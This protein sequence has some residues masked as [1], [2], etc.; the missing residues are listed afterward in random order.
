MPR[1]P[2]ALRYDKRAVV[3]VQANIHA[4]EVEGKEAALMLARDIVLD[5]K[6]PYLDKVVLLVAPDL[7]RRRQ[8]QDGPPQPHGPGRPGEG[9]G[10]PPQ[11]PEPRP[12]PGR[13]EARE[14]GDAG[15]RPQRPRALGPAPARRLPHDRR[16][17]STRSR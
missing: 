5:P 15:P 4:G 7:Q 12:Q 1:D 6:L 3:Y 2:L 10:R 13:H 16:L 17:R 9:L 11:R 8:R 14:P